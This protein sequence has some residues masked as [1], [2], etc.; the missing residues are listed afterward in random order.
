MTF[1]Y[2][3][4]RPDAE[5]PVRKHPTDAGVDVFAVE[6][7]WVQPL[8]SATVHTG[9]T[10]EVK[11]GWMVEIRPKSRSNFLI[12]AGIVD[13]GYQGEI[14]VKVVNFTDEPLLIKQ[15]DPVAQLIKVKIE[16]EPVEQL[17][18]EDIHV[19]VSARGA[20]GGILGNS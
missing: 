18:L 11:P 8:S 13:A 14:M 5:S 1:K 4:L 20:T 12:G 15:G 6:P 17:R 7:M 3:L 10:V 2:A 9:V 19:E 16:T